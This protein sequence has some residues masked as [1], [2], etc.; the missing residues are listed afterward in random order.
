MTGEIEQ[1]WND[2]RLKMNGVFIGCVTKD[3]ADHIMRMQEELA[4]LRADNRLLRY[5]LAM[6][7]NSATHLI[8][9]DDGELQCGACL[10][11]FVRDPAS[12]IHKKIKDARLR[13]IQR[14]FEDGKLL[15]EDAV[16]APPD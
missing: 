13:E 1:P 12:T 2:D 7:H 16:H 4:R 3:N 8:Y 11:D 6:A 15:S 10:V 9:G 5:L 14:A